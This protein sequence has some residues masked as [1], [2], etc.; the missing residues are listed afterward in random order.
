MDQKNI[1]DA[2]SSSKGKGKEATA[3]MPTG[4]SNSQAP[5]QQKNGD[6]PSD[7]TFTTRLATSTA[8]LSRAA[9]T[10]LPDI[11]NIHSG[12]PTKAQSGAS[13]SNASDP[14]YQRQTATY[15][16]QNSPR[17]ITGTAFAPSRHSTTVGDQQYDGF[18]D[19]Q[20][21]LEGSVQLQIPGAI[22]PANTSHVS[23]PF[24][25]WS[26][27]KEQEARD[28]QQVI[29]LL[30]V[31][32]KLDDYDANG[33]SLQTFLSLKEESSLRKALFGSSEKTASNWPRLLDFQ[34]DFL[35]GENITEL[36][37]HFGVADPLQARA[38]WMDSWSD[39]L[40]SYTEEVWGDLGSLAREA[41]R[42][43]DEA[44][45]QG[46]TSAGPGGMQ[47]LHRLRQILAH[48]RGH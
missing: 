34:P 18:M 31:P 29:D 42:E 43:I 30:D 1:Y 35:L 15:H 44:R 21:G 45:G 20:I 47:A 8:A 22:G 36:Q 46:T 25:I 6:A 41:Q 9:L 27:V 38:M 17:P 26:D 37:Q 48:V 39:V 24:G 11:R 19:A 16:G 28:G 4:A 7:E 13:S 40:T 33:D 23:H 2:A 3:A 5:Q 32:E 12:A 10:G 14:V